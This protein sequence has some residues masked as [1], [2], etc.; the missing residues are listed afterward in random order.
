MQ[1]ALQEKIMAKKLV[2][3]VG[4]VFM[5]TAGAFAQSEWYNSYSPSVAKSKM[6]INAGIGYGF[7][8][9]YSLGIPPISASV[10]FRLPVKVPIM[11]GAFGA[12]STWGY[13]TGSGDYKID[14]TYINIGFGGQLAYHFNFAEKLDVYTGMSLGYVIQTAGI[15]YGS[16]Y[17]NGYKP[18]GYSGVSFLLWGSNVGARFFFTEKLGAYLELGYSGLQVAS[19]GITFKL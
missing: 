11:A 12:F 19:A 18:G 4:L 7:S 14:V 9:R 16:A 15:K 8:I 13:N 2:L 6:L 17:D 1:A 3:V 5:T 10:D